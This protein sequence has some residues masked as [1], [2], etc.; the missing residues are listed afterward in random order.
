[1]RRPLVPWRMEGAIPRGVETPE[2][3][4]SASGDRVAAVAVRTSARSLRSRLEQPHRVAMPVRDVRAGSVAV[5]LV[6][7]IRR[8][9]RPLA[10]GAQLSGRDVMS[11]DPLVDRGQ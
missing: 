5:G 8:A 7:R 9:D 11:N 1:M 2:G 10:D 3:G 4:V 6:L